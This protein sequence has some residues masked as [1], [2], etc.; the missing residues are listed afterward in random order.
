MTL[1]CLSLP[2]AA[3]DAESVPGVVIADSA[4]SVSNA[5][6]GLPSAWS[7]L[8]SAPLPITANDPV[9]VAESSSLAANPFSAGP[10]GEPSGYKGSSYIAAPGS[11]GRMTLNQCLTDTTHNK[12]CRVHW[13]QLLITSS[14]FNAFQNAGNLYTSYWYRYE[15]T[16]GPWIQRYFNSV[17]GWRWNQWHDGNP[18]TDDY[19]GHPM[20]GGISNSIWIQNDPKGMTAEFGNNRVYWRSRL[21]ALAFSTAYSFEWKFGPF[22]EAGVGHS[23]DHT[24]D[25]VNGVLQND[26]GVV[27]L[28]TTPVGGFGWTIAE[29]FVDKHVVKK[30]EEKPRGYVSLTLISFLTPARATANIFRFR[31]PWYRDGRQVKAR[32]AWGDLDSPDAIPAGDQL[33]WG[34]AKGE[35]QGPSVAQ[36][37]S[38]R[39][40]IAPV[41][42]AAVYK[43]LWP[44][45]GGRHEFG[46]LWGLSLMS[47]HLFGRAGDIKY[48]PVYLGYSYLLNP[49]S[50]W[51]WLRYSPEITALAMLDEPNYKATKTTGVEDFRQRIYG[52]GLS[53]IGL[54][55]S[56]FP[57]SRVQ[58]FFSLNSGMN[59]YASPVLSPQGSRWMYTGDFGFGLEIFRKPRQSFSIGYRYTHLGSAGTGAQNPGTDANVFYLKISRY[60]SKGYR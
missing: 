35:P 29:D 26:T 58:P 43:P 15:T 24:T 34:H 45:L 54:R 17:L 31:P 8:P 5:G 57:K 28:V 60:K 18:F 2:L 36:L 12:D 14:V 49:N 19:I 10:Y 38:E 11:T 23:G 40:S 39:G 1:S 16:T 25:Y 51:V 9:E 33:A 6:S 59:Y 7:D 27:E 3:Q 53:P 4:V 30:L 47:G 48:M 55:S 42:R 22:G 44:D 21:R 37:L 41:M 20:M 50:T 52:G 13:R 32:T 56:F 46:A